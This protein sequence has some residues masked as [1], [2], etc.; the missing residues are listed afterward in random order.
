[1]SKDTNEIKKLEG[2]NTLINDLVA[3]PAFLYG[4]QA[5]V[6][7][8]D[9]VF[10]KYY[11]TMRF[12]F[13]PNPLNAMRSRVC[14]EDRLLLISGGRLCAMLARRLLCFNGECVVR[15]ALRLGT[16]VL[17]RRHVLP[18]SSATCVATLEGH[19]KWVLSVAF[20]PTA[21]LM[22][23]GNHDSTVILWLLSCD[24]SSATCVA[25]LK[26]HSDCVRSVAFHPKALLLATGSGDCT[27]NLWL[28]S[29]DNSSA[30]RVATLKGN[31][32]VYSAA[33]HPNLPLLAVGSC[34]N[35]ARL[36][37]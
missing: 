34:D 26:G 14:S 20:H 36:W 3:L 1:M 32:P 35:T 33:F 21:P 27:V 17:S 6:K 31:S 28:L 25:T 11:R 13:P 4:F 18:N 22:A 2:G 9:A 24:N 5:A 16:S 10:P 8:L 12:S 7:Q 37:R 29:C 15:D 23:T 30:T 19:S